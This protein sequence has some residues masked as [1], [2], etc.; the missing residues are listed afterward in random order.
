MISVSEHDKAAGADAF[1][2]DG[3]T[4]EKNTNA[5]GY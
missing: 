4:E 5:K 3:V 1:M 2:V